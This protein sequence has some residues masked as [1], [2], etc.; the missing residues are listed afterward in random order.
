MSICCWFPEYLPCYPSPKSGRAKKI[1]GLQRED[2]NVGKSSPQ[3]T[4][5]KGFI[6]GYRSQ[7]ERQI[8]H[9][10][11]SHCRT[12]LLNPGAGRPWNTCK[13]WTFTLARTDS[14]S[15]LKALLI[16]ILS[17]HPG[18]LKRFNFK[19]PFQQR[20]ASSLARLWVAGNSCKNFL[21]TWSVSKGT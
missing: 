3:E 12:V 11:R 1:P 13:A 14:C 7:A 9:C 4:S 2:R 5:I 21:A 10:S 8:G 18:K 17:W 15:R 20:A 6:K 16:N 19:Y